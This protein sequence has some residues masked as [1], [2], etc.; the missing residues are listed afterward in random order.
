M[1]SDPPR[2]VDTGDTMAVKAHLDEEIVKI[3]MDMGWAEDYFW[4]NIKLVLLVL[5]TCIALLA[6]FYP[7]PYPENRG[8]LAICVVSFFILNGVLQLISYFVDQDKIAILIRPKYPGIVIRSSF[9]RF[10]V[11]YTATL[12]TSKDG[13]VLAKFEHSIAEYFTAKGEFAE[14]VFARDVQK[15]YKTA[16][17]KAG[18]AQS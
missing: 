16:T 15:W 14:L 7:A 17:A 5:A 10:Q 13:V 4:Y 18:K 3:F 9:P 1:G 8:L 2:I 6:Q 11:T 12:E